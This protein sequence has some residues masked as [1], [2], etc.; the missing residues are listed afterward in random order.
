MG[1]NTGTDLWVAC[2]VQSIINSAK[3]AY[4]DKRLSILHR[5]AYCMRALGSLSE[6]HKL[7]NL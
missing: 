6:K 4:T 2:L 1:F 3:K 5:C 7:G